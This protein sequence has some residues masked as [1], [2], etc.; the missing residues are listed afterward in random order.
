MAAYL[1]AQESGEGRKVSVSSWQA[2]CSVDDTYVQ[3]LQ[4]LNVLPKRIGNG[5]PTPSSRSSGTLATSIS[6]PGTSRRK[7]SCP[8]IRV[9]SSF[10]R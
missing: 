2:I 4:G 6:K 10:Y 7:S 8:A 3:G 9:N 5:F 1:D